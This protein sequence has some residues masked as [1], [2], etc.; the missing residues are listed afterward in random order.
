MYTVTFI[1]WFSYRV[2]YLWYWADEYLQMHSVGYSIIS[3]KCIIY[4][5]KKY[6]NIAHN[7]EKLFILT[8]GFASFFFIIYV[9]LTEAMSCRSVFNYNI[10]RPCCTFR[11][12]TST[13]SL[14]TTF[15][16]PGIFSDNKASHFIK[17][18]IK[19]Q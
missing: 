13:V 1:L 9:N 7:C 19:S 2:H 17:S 14:F 11:V 5:N 15:A 18:L 3:N 6:Q 4:I 16:F 12:P 10:L 8:G